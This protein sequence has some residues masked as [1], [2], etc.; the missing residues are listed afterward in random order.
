MQF[1]QNMQTIKGSL[2]REAY[3]RLSL[4]ICAA[5]RGENLQIEIVSEGIPRK[6]IRFH[7]K[8]TPITMYV[9]SDC[10]MEIT[11]TTHHLSIDYIGE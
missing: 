9:Y 4:L 3:E 7:T 6:L 8:T 10:G 5:L 1:K 11:T 2:R